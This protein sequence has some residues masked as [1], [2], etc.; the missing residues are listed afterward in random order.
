MKQCRAGTFDSTKRWF[1]TE[2]FRDKE[3]IKDIRGRIGHHLRDVCVEAVKL[4]PKSG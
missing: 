3:V 2:A 4:P 1:I